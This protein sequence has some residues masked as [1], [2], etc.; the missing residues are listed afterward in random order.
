LILQ[1]IRNSVVKYIDDR[2]YTL[3]AQASFLGEVNV[4]GIVF[5]SRLGD[6][7]FDILSSTIA[8]GGN[9]P[10]FANEYHWVFA[11][12]GCTRIPIDVTNIELLKPYLDE[13][14]KIA[15]YETGH[16]LKSLDVGISAIARNPILSYN[17]NYPFG[18]GW[19]YYP[20]VVE[21][22]EITDVGYRW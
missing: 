11:A 14:W 20:M 9:I 6:N 2:F 7:S 19:S 10:W 16:T 15:E 8:G 13:I 22:I 4:S 17:A 18:E 1:E 21:L 5:V 12:W 3:I